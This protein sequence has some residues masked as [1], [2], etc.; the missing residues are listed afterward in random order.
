MF[1]VL[2]LIIILI[3]ILSTGCGGSSGANIEVG[4]PADIPPPAPLAVDEWK[5]MT[6]LNQKY[7]IS[8]L[9]RLRASDPS[10]ESE[11]AWEKFMRE[12]V[13]PQMKKEKPR[14]KESI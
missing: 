13:G 14:P 10:L 4:V 11:K 8:T 5:A 6:D 7:E 12:V 9:E 1:R 2:C 3:P